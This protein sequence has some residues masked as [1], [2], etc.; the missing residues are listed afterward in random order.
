MSRSWFWL[1]I[2]VLL[3]VA[4]V[5]VLAPEQGNNPSVRTFSVRLFNGTWAGYEVIPTAG[6]HATFVNAS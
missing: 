5:L 3:A 2:L 6:N 1:L 4:M